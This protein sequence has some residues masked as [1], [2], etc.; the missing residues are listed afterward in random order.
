M[1]VFYIQSVITALS[2]LPSHLN[3]LKEKHEREKGNFEYVS[4]FLWGDRSKWDTMEL[5][6]KEK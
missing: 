3:M 2:C 5:E 1:L 4:W 6:H